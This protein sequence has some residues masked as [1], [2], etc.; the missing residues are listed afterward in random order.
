[1][2][3]LLP[4]A[5]ASLLVASC[6]PGAGGGTLDVATTTSV[7]NSGLMAVLL[8]QFEAEAG[9]RVRVH[10]AGSGRA[11]EMLHDQV[12]D[13]V[14]SHAPAAEARMLASHPAWR[15]QPFAT[16][17]FV[18]AGPDADPA[19]VREARDATDAFARIAAARHWFVSRGD[20]SGTHER[21]QELWSS[22]G[23]RL[24]PDRL[25]VSGG[26]MGTTLRQADERAAYTLTD[27]ATFRQL[28]AR[29]AIRVLFA[30]DA[31]L[32][33][34]YSLV[35]DPSSQAADRFAAWLTAGRGRTAVEGYRI[36]G[37]APFTPA[38]QRGSRP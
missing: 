26:G 25:L 10:A 37:V 38:P 35:W 16:N 18:I 20:G 3:L 29:L 23:V 9:V 8:P 15:H 32:T 7:V 14:I 1:M 31:R 2:R 28:S 11:L 13:L 12:V 33:N 27:D 24:P 22:A 36:D 17:Q 21:E 5:V 34:T 4:V 30:G 6:G 19:R